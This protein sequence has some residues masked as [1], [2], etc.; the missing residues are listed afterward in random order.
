MP[1]IL[2]DTDT[3]QLDAPSGAGTATPPDAWFYVVAAGATFCI[4]LWM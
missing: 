2:R 3:A 4:V 1:V